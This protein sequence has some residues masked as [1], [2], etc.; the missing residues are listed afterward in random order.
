MAWLDFKTLSML[1]GLVAFLPALPGDEPS[2]ADELGISG[3][4]PVRRAARVLARR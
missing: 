4:L 1:V 2:L 3:R